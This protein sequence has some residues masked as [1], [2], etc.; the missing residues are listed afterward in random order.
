MK[1]YTALID[2][3]GPY[4]LEEAQA[5]PGYTDGLYMVIGKLKNKKRSHLQYIGIAKDLNSRLNGNHHKI[6]EVTRDKVIWLGELASPRV[7]GQKVK[8][9]DRLLDLAE[10]S[11]AYFLQLELNGKKTK[12]PPDCSIVVYNRWWKKENDSPCG[13]RPHR[14]WP[15]LIDFVDDDHKAKLVW[16]GSKQKVDYPS[17]FVS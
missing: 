3:Y 5:A 15:D 1:T 12:S 8:V 11:H 7:A 16:F 6:P 10:W 17:E 9:I 2:W 13:K 4:T 14:E